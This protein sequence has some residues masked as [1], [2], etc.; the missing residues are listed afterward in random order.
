MRDLRPTL[1]ALSD[2][3]PDL[4]HL[5]ENLDPLLEASKTSLPAT[6]EI[7][8]GLRPVLGE[9]GPWLGELNPILAWIAEHQHTVTDIFANLGV[10]IS[11]KTGSR[12]PQATGHYLRQF[13]PSGAETA[14]VYPNRLASNRG[15]T[16]INPLSLVGPD[17]AEKGIIDAFDC[18][19]VS[20]EGD[21]PSPEGNPA[22]FNQR[23]HEWGKG[24][25]K[26]P[27]VTAEDY[28]K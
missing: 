2:L 23:P 5:F 6:R 15:N 13:G 3:S 8:E 12:D 19:N 26:F 22:C 1:I 25:T 7:F 24:L 9:L 4:K 10:A 11:A 21:K 28:S 16:Y 17:R 27:R 18:R 20:G 14:A